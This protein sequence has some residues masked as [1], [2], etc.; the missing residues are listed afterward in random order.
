M[1]RL[2]IYSVDGNWGPWSPYTCPVTCGGGTYRRNRICNNPAPARGG[3]PCVGPSQ[4]NNTCNTQPCPTIPT[5]TQGIMTFSSIELSQLMWLWY[6]SHR[7]PAKAQ[8]SLHIRAVSPEPSL[9]AHIIYGSSRRVRPNIRHLAPLDGSAYTFKEL[10][11]GGRKVPQ[12]HDMA[13]L[14]FYICV[15]GPLTRN[16]MANWPYHAY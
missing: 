12:S 14:F 15:Y 13:Q 16:M 6:L 9:F 10:V 8:A 1:I 2:I 4:M 3:R 11:Y 7:R 5:T